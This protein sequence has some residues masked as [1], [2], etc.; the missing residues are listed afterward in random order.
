MSGTLSDASSGL[1]ITGTVR[2]DD[3]L[4]VQAPGGRYSVTLDTG[5]YPIEAQAP[6]HYPMTDTIVV[7]RDREQSFALQPTPCLLLVDDDYDG[8]G[9]LY[10]DQVYYS[11]ALADLGIGYALWSVA[12]D[13]DGPPQSVL[14][15][16]RGVVW[17]TGRDWDF[18][19]TMSDQGALAGYLDQGGR[20]FVSGQDIGMDLARE[21]PAAPFYED[22]LHARYLLDDSGYR[23]VSG[24]GIM[25]GLELTIQGGDGAD[26]QARPSDIDAVGDASGLFYYAD[27][28]WAATA[29]ADDTYRVAY[30]AFGFEAISSYAH[31]RET[32]RRVLE[33]LGPCE[34]PALQPSA[35]LPVVLGQ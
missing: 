16:Y 14:D 5:T 20:L 35:H 25:S 31:R 1:L 10:D 29:F 32:M 18:T 33:F 4:V 34:I 8:L 24:Y 9:N 21:T 11:S 2:I 12:D 17:L 13:A 7:D 28:D 3:Q 15:L 22:Y 23:D 30:F 19:L 26:N 27:G 6:L